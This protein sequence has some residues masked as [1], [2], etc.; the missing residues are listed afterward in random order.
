MPASEL[1]ERHFSAIGARARVT[2][3]TGGRVALDVRSDSRGEHFLIGLPHTADALVLDA[4][5]RERHLV[6]MVREGAESSRF[7]CGHDERHWFV[8]AIPESA[9]SVTTVAQ[10]QHALRPAPVQMAAAGLRP[11]LRRRRRNPAFVRQGEWFFLPVPELRPAPALVLRN[12][13]LSRGRG[14]P[15]RMEL[16]LRRRGTLVHVSRA[17]PTGLSQHEFDALS[18]GERR[19]Q[20]WTQ[21]VR[22]AQVFARARVSHPDHATIVLD[23]WHEV[24]MNTEAGARAMRHVAFLD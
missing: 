20:S 7:L 23:T 2:P 19:R 10:A 1:L 5:K 14:K 15:H 12:E 8:A 6:V 13:P 22:D 21:M 3:S 24:L 16:A 18:E 9:A 11:K 4:R 17:H